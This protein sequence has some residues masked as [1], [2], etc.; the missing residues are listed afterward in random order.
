MIFDFT[1]FFPEL[2]G[3]SEPLAARMTKYS[4]G[5]AEVVAARQESRV[6]GKRIDPVRIFKIDFEG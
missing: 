4:S 3:E 5:G 2:Q 1:F 6:P